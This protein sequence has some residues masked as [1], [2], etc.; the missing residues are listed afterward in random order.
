MK[1]RRKITRRQFLS[2]SA[3]VS[4]GLVVAACGGE[5]ATSTPVPEAVAT[6]VPAEPTA[7][8]AP[9]SMYQE[10]PMLAALVASG[11]LPPVD[12]RLPKNPWVVPVAEMTG[13]YGG[14]IRRGFNGQSDRWGPTKHIDKTLAWW[15]QNLVM[16]P[17]LVESWELSDDASEWTFHLREG[18]KWSDG[19]PFTSADFTWWYENDLL[20]TEITPTPHR[21][22]RSGVPPV[23]MEMEAPDD[24]TVIFRYANPKP[25]LLMNVAR[26]PRRIY[27]PGHYMAQYHMDLT[28]DKDALQAEVEAAGFGSWDEYYRDNRIWWN[29]NPERP[30]VTA[31]VA[32]NDLSSDLFVMNRNP[33]Y[34][35][36]DADRNQLPYLDNVHH[37]LHETTEVFN[38][39]IVNGEIDFQGRRVG[40]ENFTLFKE[41]E[42]SGD[43]KVL[44]GIGAGHEAMQPN[45]TTK[46]EKV[47]EFFNDVRVRHAMSLAQNRDEMNELVL[48]GLMT[49]RQYS[50]ISM[51]PNYYPKLSNAFIE[52]DPETANQLLDEAGYSEKDAD[53]FRLWKDGSGPVSFIIESDAEAGTS[54]EDLAQ[55]FIRYLAEVGIKASYNYAERSLFEAH[56]DSNEIEAAFWGGDR[57]VVP[58]APEAQIFRGVQIDRPWA[59][60][61]GKWFNDPTDPHAVEPPEG[62]WIKDIWDIW[63]Q[64]AAEPDPDKQNAL[65]EGILDIWAEQLPMIGLLGE[66]PKLVIV[67]NG[68][69]NYLPGMPYDDPIGD[70]H[71]L[72]TET[73]FWENPEE[74][75]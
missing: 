8:S 70:E 48:D 1:Q 57:T 35:G 43:Y 18:M 68:L 42:E 29:A 36:V 49:P 33:Y 30:H 22:Y 54:R 14:L 45:L 12:E 13:N 27:M 51:S 44:V 19:E 46:N 25:L 10:A 65:F 69:H 56:Q 23:V 6:A 11:A 73:L 32:E 28:D 5:D 63:E 7:P 21:Q 17:R 71:F 47:N 2:L 31:W 66:Q 64:V 41:N 75:M 37:R 58:L 40:L 24:Y 3:G 9:V 72:H 62:H 61:W 39:W 20:N 50:P 53:G 74:H 16:Q 52:Y 34:F 26:E 67:K 4:A 15:D 55:L 59:V 60:A 38:L